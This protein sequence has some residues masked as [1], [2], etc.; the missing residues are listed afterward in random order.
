M[1]PYRTLIRVAIITGSGQGVGAA[2]ARLFAEHGA[3]VVVSD[4]DAAK[5]QQ[6]AKDIQK[7]GGTALAVPG[8]VTDP[9][10]PQKIVEAT[11]QEFGVLHHLVNN[12]GYTWD[13][14]IHKM[15]DKQWQAMLL[16]KAGLI[17]LTKTVAK[18]LGPFNIRCNCIAFSFIQTRLI[19]DRTGGSTVKVGCTAKMQLSLHCWPQHAKM[20]DALQVGG[21]SVKVGMPNASQITDVAKQFIPLRRL[22]SPEE[23][24][25]SMLMLTCPFSSYIS[26][27]ILEVTGG[28]MI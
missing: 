9:A 7:A 10:F 15:T 16:A 14:V 2:A 12:A 24:A 28:G 25:G 13:G 6:V 4:I 20:L 19:A 5:A 1:L 18:E 23:A 26:G 22:G 8:D 17:G 3:K 21:E 11:I 27:Q